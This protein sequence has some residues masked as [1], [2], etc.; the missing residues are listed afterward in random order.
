M[1]PQSLEGKDGGKLS[2]RYREAIEALAFEWIKDAVDY[3]QQREILRDCVL[4]EWLEEQ[5]VLKKV[6][7]AFGMTPCACGSRDCDKLAGMI[8]LDPAAVKARKIFEEAGYHVPGDPTFWEAQA[9][10]AGQAGKAA[11]E[12]ALAEGKSRTEA[13]EIALAAAAARAAEDEEE[14]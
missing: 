13:N 10:R 1:E 5:D 6:W 11:F 9:L 12:A 4:P 7:A 3:D 8:G 2:N 14:F